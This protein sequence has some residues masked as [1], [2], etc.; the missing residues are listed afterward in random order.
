MMA[1]A[2]GLLPSVSSLILNYNGARWIESCL[3]SLVGASVSDAEL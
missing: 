2:T 1:E 3:A